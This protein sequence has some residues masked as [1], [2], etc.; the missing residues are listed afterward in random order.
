M[1]ILYIKGEQVTDITINLPIIIRIM[2]IRFLGI[3]IL[4]RIAN[5]KFTDK[6]Y[7]VQD[8]IHA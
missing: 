3:L 8:E 2:Q 1:H 6:I 5:I 7:T 4:H